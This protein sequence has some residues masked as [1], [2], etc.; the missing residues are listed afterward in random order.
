M[1]L[2]I[3]A[4]NELRLSGRF[5]VSDSTPSSRLTSRPSTLTYVA[6]P[7]SVDVIGE[8]SIGGF[9]ARIRRPLRARDWS[10]WLYK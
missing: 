3:V 10:T 8:P 4:V 1:P 7:E 2:S 9:R 6:V 5:S